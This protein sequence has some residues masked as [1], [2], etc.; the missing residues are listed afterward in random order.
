MGASVY[1][2]ETSDLQGLRAETVSVH[3]LSGSHRALP[4]GPSAGGAEAV[5]GEALDAGGLEP[6]HPTPAHPQR[7]IRRSTRFC[8]DSR[9]P[10]GKNLAVNM[11]IVAKWNGGERELI[12]VCDAD[13]E[14]MAETA[15]VGVPYC[16]KHSDESQVWPRPAEWVWVEVRR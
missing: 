6:G 3:A 7:K 9:P 11:A 13:F 15:V 10:P 2:A 4:Q 8:G 1:A 14:W 16:F 5:P 12:C